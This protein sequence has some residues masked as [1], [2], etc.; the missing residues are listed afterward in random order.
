VNPAAAHK[1]KMLL[2]GFE[3]AFLVAFREGKRVS[4]MQAGAVLT[5][6]E[7]LRTL[8]SGSVNKSLLRYKV[9]VGT[10]VGNVPMDTMGK[11]IEMG[12]VTPVTSADAVRYYYGSFK[13]RRS[14]DDA[15]KAI[16]LKGFADAFVV[17]EL[18][19]RI[20]SGEDADRLMSEP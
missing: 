20:I 6:P 2:N 5:G 4:M 7:D 8:P 13:D 3:G 16:Q 1:V 14:A 17:G 19:G 12:D 10:F 11:L 18:N 15:R 9:Q